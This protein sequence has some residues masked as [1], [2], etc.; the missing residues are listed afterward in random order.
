[1][2]GTDYPPAD[3]GMPPIKPAFGSIT[4]KVRGTNH[5]VTGIPTYVRLSGLYAD[6][7]HWLGVGNAPFDIGGEARSNLNLSVGMNRLDDRRR[8]L[9]AL[10]HVDRQVDRTG[11]MVGLDTFEGQAFD[12]ILGRSKEA[13]DLNRE[14]PRVR[15]LYGPGL[16]EQLLLARRLCEGGCGFVTLHYANAPQAWDMHGG[17]GS[18]LSIANQLAQACPPMDHAV[19]TFLEDLAQRGL[20]EKIL[21]VI[22]G[23]FGRTPR[24]NG[25]AGRD[26]WGPLCTLALAGGGLRMGQVVGESSA[27]AEVPKSTPIEPKDLMATIFHVLGIDLDIQFPDQFGRPQYLLP[28]GARPIAELV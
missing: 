12:L 16:G 22:T 7:P 6:G 3:A 4:A 14:D 13:F 1:M 18:N 27:K 8:L 10:D 19:A 9:K 20:S 26:H 2:T 28:D 5:P 17:P 11:Q 25:S 21:L 23:E 24:I 15:S